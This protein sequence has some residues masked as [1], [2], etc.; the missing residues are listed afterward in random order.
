M[1]KSLLKPSAKPTHVHTKIAILLN[2]A[3]RAHYDLSHH[4]DWEKWILNSLNVHNSKLQ[5]AISSYPDDWRPTYLTT[6]FV[7]LWTNAHVFKRQQHEWS[8]RIS[9]DMWTM[10][11][12]LQLQSDLHRSTYSLPLNTM[13][14]SR[15]T[16]T[17]CL[18]T[19]KVLMA[20]RMKK[21]VFRVV[22]PCRSFRGAC[23]L[24]HQWGWV[25]TQMMDFYCWVQKPRRHPSSK[26]L[27]IMT[28]LSCFERSY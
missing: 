18:I 5:R 15:R 9:T 28:S 10:L 17:I 21:A 4:W 7:L 20:T 25:I 6:L 23:C 26:V 16:N 19:S 2:K 27:L 24:N 12:L 13:W 1:F 14:I 22:E 11:L 3:T 8:P